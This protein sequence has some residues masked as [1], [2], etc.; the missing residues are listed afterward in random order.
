[1]PRTRAVTARI[2][3]TNEIRRNRNP[4]HPKP[5]GLGR[6]KGLERDVVLGC[7]RTGTLFGAHRL[8][9]IFLRAVARLTPEP[10]CGSR[11]ARPEKHDIVGNDLG[12]VVLLVFFVRPLAGLQSTLDEAL[13]AFRQV[14]AT[15]LRE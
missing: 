11:G 13:A 9:G 1:M 2:A 12:G 4:R 3:R 8:R 7:R 6:S 14:L 5:T 15:E 10:S